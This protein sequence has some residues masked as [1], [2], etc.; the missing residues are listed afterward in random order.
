MIFKKKSIHQ[1]LNLEFKLSNNSKSGHALHVTASAFV[2]PEFKWPIQ[3]PTVT[4]AGL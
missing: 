4:L 3:N 1:I 2:N